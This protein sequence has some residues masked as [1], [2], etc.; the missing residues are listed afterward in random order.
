MMMMRDD[1]HN[2][3]NG[4]R[5]S[6]TQMMVA[7][8]LAVMELWIEMNLCIELTCDFCVGNARGEVS[9][10]MVNQTR[11]TTW[12]TSTL[13]LVRARAWSLGCETTY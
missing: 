5:P 7:S 1:P 9:L 4:P 13:R 11:T 3:A 6:G 10:R 2:D 8:L 12:M